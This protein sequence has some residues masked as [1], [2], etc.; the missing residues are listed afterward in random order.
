MASK[1]WDEAL[2]HICNCVIHQM[3]PSTHSCWFTIK[4]NEL[5]LYHFLRDHFI[6][7]ARKLLCV[8][9]GWFFF[10]CLWVCFFFLR[11][12]G[13]G[14]SFQCY[15]FLQC[16]D[17]LCTSPMFSNWKRNYCSLVPLLCTDLCHGEGRSH[18]TLC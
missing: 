6:Q 13:K 7:V 10:F 2:T 5:N 8:F 14:P 4:L 15:S 18:E 3:R 17:K 1:T 11:G 9:G 12:R 16:S